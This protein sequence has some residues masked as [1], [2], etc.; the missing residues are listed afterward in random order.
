MNYDFYNPQNIL[1]IDED[2]IE[3]PEDFVTSTYIDID[4]AI[5]NK[6]SLDNWVKNV[7][8]L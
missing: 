7:F 5:L 4:D 1:V 8:N 6:Y 3:I 2:N